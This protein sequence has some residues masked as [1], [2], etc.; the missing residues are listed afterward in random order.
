MFLRVWN[1]ELFDLVVKSN[2]G[3]GVI[4]NGEGQVYIPD[5][6]IRKVIN[7]DIDFNAMERESGK[8]FSLDSV[9]V[10][11]NL[12]SV[13][14]MPFDRSRL[15]KMG[16]DK[17]YDLVNLERIN[18][19][20]AKKIVE[21]SLKKYE[22]AHK[23]AFGALAQLEECEY[24]HTLEIEAQDNVNVVDVSKWKDLDELVIHDCKNLRKVSG[25][26]E[27]PEFAGMKISLVGC[28]NVEECDLFE[29]LNEY[30]KGRVVGF[31]CTLDMGS[32]F[33][34]LSQNRE[35]GEAIRSYFNKSEGV[36]VLFEGNG[37]LNGA[38]MKEL[39]G[40]IN[41]DLVENIERSNDYCADISHIYS[42][43]TQNM[44]SKEFK[45]NLEMFGLVGNA[46]AKL[47]EAYLLTAG[48]KAKNVECTKYEEWQGKPKFNLFNNREITAVSLGRNK[49][50]W[51]LLDAVAD[52]GE[53]EFKHFLKTPKEMEEDGYILGEEFLGYGEAVERQGSLQEYVHQF[54]TSVAKNVAVANH[55]Q[56]EV[57]TADEAEITK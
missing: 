40:R 20:N 31:G 32:Y 45:K 56:E 6:E 37:V 49:S 10:L 44:K 36:Q 21:N 55:K 29:A 35:Q 53:S 25:F 42:W 57:I 30:P 24:I 19:V 8:P 48:Y 1:P 41:H 27:G 46:R 16:E 51:Y 52:A 2:P 11:K 34:I 7:L 22:N 26:R 38:K 50:E 13:R 39:H 28:E 54:G 5:E 33:K 23:L 9:S 3:V 43:I 15:I 4:E 47:L 12:R 18:P 17:L 14:V